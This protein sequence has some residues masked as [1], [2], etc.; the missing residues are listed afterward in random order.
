MLTPDSRQ[1]TLTARTHTYTFSEVTIAK[2]NKSAAIRDMISQNPRA[3]ASE[4][5]SLL[6]GKRIKVRPHLV[7]LVKGKMKRIKRREKSQRAMAT[8]GNGN[9]VELILK[10]KDLAR[11]AGGIGSLKQLVDALAEYV[12]SYNVTYLYDPAGYRMGKPER[13][14]VTTITYDAANRTSR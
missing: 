2:V 9:A 13:G 5:I 1:I 12:G 7:Y 3:T 6:A 4:I 8:V 10:V 14:T 11:Q